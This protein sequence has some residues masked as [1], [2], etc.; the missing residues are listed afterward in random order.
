[1]IVPSKR[2]LDGDDDDIQF[3][4]EKPV[5]RRRSN[6]KPPVIPMSDVPDTPN[7][8]TQLPDSEEKDTE[9]RLSTGMVSLTPDI[10]AMELA[11][12]LRGVSMPMLENFVLD[13]PPRKTRIQSPPE[14]SPKQLPLTVS[15]AMLN[16]CG[17]RQIPNSE[18]PH[19]PHTLCTSAPSFPTDTPATMP[20]MKTNL[21]NTQKTHASEV[22]VQVHGCGSGPSFTYANHTSPIGS[23][24]IHMPPIPIPS[25]QIS[26]HMPCWGSSNTI[27]PETQYQSHSP[28]YPQK[29]TCQICSRLRYQAQVSAAQGQPIASAGLVPPVTPLLHCH[30]SYGQ[31]FHPQMATIPTSGMHR[32]PP[33][34]TPVVMPVNDRELTALPTHPQCQ[35]PLRQI[36]TQQQKAEDSYKP[37]APETPSKTPLSQPMQTKRTET[38]SNA[39]PTPLKSSTSLT[40]PTCRKPSPNLVVDVAETCQEKFPFEEVAKRHN[41]PLDKVFEIFSAI[42]QVPLL[43]CPTD[44]RRQGK[45]ATA[46]IKEYNK[47]KK[48]IR[49]GGNGTRAEGTISAADIAASLG[50]I[51]LPGGFTMGGSNGPSRST[52]RP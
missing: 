26:Q 3:V 38:A 11:Y 12:A 33:G 49:S 18:T 10:N 25:P 24:A 27:P 34:F 42:I 19:T 9:R 41:V 52:K 23:N 4:S 48:D 45:L 46:R 14:L 31:H 51:E 22:D 21:A 7:N 36:A 47:A 6:E 28:A 30:P 5:K 40:K 2:Q 39:S 32:F 29:Q 17:H 8:A 35:H 20:N 1:M 50:P 15:Q 43:R 16:A 13:Q 37:T 44:R